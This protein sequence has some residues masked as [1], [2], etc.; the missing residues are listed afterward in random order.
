MKSVTRRAGSWIGQTR[1]RSASHA[2]SD[3][4]RHQF[5]VAGSRLELRLTLDTSRHHPP[6]GYMA[7]KA[8]FGVGR[9]LGRAVLF[10]KPSAWISFLFVEV[11]RRHRWPAWR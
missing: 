7:S 10:A 6:D 4:D 1:R 5:K 2:Y 11:M 3:E 8:V 9:M